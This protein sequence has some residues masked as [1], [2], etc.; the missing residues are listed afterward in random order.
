M[1]HEALQGRREQSFATRHRSSW[2]PSALNGEYEEYHPLGTTSWWATDGGT[3]V[4]AKRYRYTG[5]ERDD[6]TGLG[7][8]GARYY[9]AWLGRWERPDPIGLEGGGVNRLA[10]VR[11]RPVALRDSTGLE[12]EPTLSITDLYNAAAT[13]DL[14]SL[15]DSFVGA[16]DVIDLISMLDAAPTER[17][18]YRADLDGELSGQASEY[19]QVDREKG[20]AAL[21]MVDSRGLAVSDASLS[22]VFQGS[23]YSEGNRGGSVADAQYDA[24]ADSMPS[25][26]ITDPSAV[27]PWL[28]TIVRGHTHGDPS[29]QPKRRRAKVFGASGGDLYNHFTF[30]A[31]MRFVVDDRNPAEGGTVLVLSNAGSVYEQLGGDTSSSRQRRVVHRMQVRVKSIVGSLADINAR[32]AATLLANTVGGRVYASDSSPQLGRFEVARPYEQLSEASE[33]VSDAIARYATT[34]Q[35]AQLRIQRI[36]GAGR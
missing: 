6:E 2:R 12:P 24:A 30:G 28:R 4:S 29:H 32:D 15:P 34:M 23:A 7:Y 33:Q 27:G 5:K 22:E 19:S 16:Q 35:R 21:L 8:H 17:A 13:N 10:Y 3:E 31:E 11:N 1:E 36:Q 14:S 9:A 26:E 18:A 20:I 25:P